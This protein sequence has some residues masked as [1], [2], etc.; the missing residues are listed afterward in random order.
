M[1]HSLG[2]TIKTVHGLGE[3]YLTT[4]SMR[5]LIGLAVKIV[6]QFL[7]NIGPK[8]RWLDLGKKLN[9]PSWRMFISIIYYHKGGP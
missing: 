1:C 9:T 3:P 5:S 2:V 4:P 6:N 7:D 8:L